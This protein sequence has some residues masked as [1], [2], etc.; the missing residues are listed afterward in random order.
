M[1]SNLH[2]LS[3]E[4]FRHAA[5]GASD[6]PNT[7]QPQ[8]QRL[9]NEAEPDQGNSYRNAVV[10]RVQLVHFDRAGMEF[11]LVWN[12]QRPLPVSVM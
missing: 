7:A 6:V 8:N 9:S 1:R 4:S 5:N 2:S 10:D 12:K 11:V 3:P